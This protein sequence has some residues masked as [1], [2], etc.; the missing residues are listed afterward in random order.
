M[1]VKNCVDDQEAVRFFINGVN[2]WE[3]SGRSLHFLFIEDINENASYLP[4]N[5]EWKM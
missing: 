5:N 3:F 2:A 1:F 4:G